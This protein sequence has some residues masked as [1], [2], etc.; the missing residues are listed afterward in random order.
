MPWISNRSSAA[1]TVSVSTKTGGSAREYTMFAN[2]LEG[3]NTN[4]WGRKGDEDVTVRF[5]NGKTKNFSVGKDKYVLV[6]EDSIIM[7]DCEAIWV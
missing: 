5:Q 6:H 3:W 7:M 2:T 4:Y 1:I